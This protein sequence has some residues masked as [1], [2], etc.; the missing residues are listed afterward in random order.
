MFGTLKRL[1]KT[2]RAPAAGEREVVYI[3]AATGRYDLEARER[4]V[5]ARGFYREQALGC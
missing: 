5:V 1:T 3:T 4:H 2:F